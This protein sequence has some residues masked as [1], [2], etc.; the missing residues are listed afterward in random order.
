ME[1]FIASFI[2]FFAVIDP[3]GT[4][5]VFIAA[6][7]SY[8]EKV[9]RTIALKATFFSALILFSCWRDYS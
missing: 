3:I 9:K 4:V 2:F 6:T 8:S 7:T 5:P 1:A